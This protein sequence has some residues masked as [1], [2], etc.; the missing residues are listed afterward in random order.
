MLVS[1]KEKKTKR[2][3]S[4]VYPEGV[5]ILTKS[6]M[7]FWNGWTKKKYNVTGYGYN[8]ENEPEKK[9]FVMQN[10]PGE[11]FIQRVLRTYFGK[12]Y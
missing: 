11:Y 8:L 7:V 3:V 4:H 10:D 9:N 5:V 1:I 6:L 2:S 12:V